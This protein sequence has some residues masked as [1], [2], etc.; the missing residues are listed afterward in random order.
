MTAI[1]DLTATEA[2]VTLGTAGAGIIGWAMKRLGVFRAWG[3]NRSM[4]SALSKDW[5]AT[6]LAELDRLERSVKDLELD[7]SRATSDGFR[8]PA[9][10]DHWTTAR[11]EVAKITETIIEQLDG[12][13]GL[14]ERTDQSQKEYAAAIAT[15]LAIQRELWNPETVRCWMPF[16]PATKVN[17]PALKERVRNYR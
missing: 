7:R 1:F 16:E 3:R 17:W 9:F 5:R 15:R 11:D 12:Y 6:I 14:L 13:I 8:T 4:R 10:I 2:W